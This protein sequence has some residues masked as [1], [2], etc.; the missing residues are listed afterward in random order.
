MIPLLKRLGFL[1]QA[2]APTQAYKDYRDD[3]LS[4]SVMA[5]QIR[6][7]YRNLFGANEYAYKLGK[8]ELVSKLR[9]LTGAAADDSNI[10][11]VAG[12]FQH[13]CQLANFEGGPPVKHTTTEQAQK[14][15]TTAAARRTGFAGELGI[16]YTINLNLPAT[17][18]IEVFNAIF[19]AL[20][21][22]ILHEE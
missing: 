21:E 14:T 2:S 6:H 10:P 19:K 5:Q 11:S 12:T 18:E 13:L 4:R 9:T 16:S 22:H 8:D 17:T 20:K 15:E 7:A 1:D 3:G